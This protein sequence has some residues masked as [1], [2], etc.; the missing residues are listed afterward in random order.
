MTNDA[1]WLTYADRRKGGLVNW[2]LHGR[3][4]PGRKALPRLRASESEIGAGQPRG[5]YQ[6]TRKARQKETPIAFDST[7]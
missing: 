2:D 1:S 4:P 3:I 5:G 7:T 6:Q